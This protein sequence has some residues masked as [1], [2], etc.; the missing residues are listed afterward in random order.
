MIESISVRWQSVFDPSRFL[1]SLSLGIVSGVAG[2]LVAGI[3]A[4]MVMRAVALISGLTPEFTI[5][6]TLFIIVLGGFL[7][8]WVGLIFGFLLP[9]LPG[10]VRLKG[11]LFGLVLSVMVAVSVLVIELEGELALAPKGITVA[12]LVSIPLIYGLVLS[13]VAARLVP[14]TVDI[15]VESMGFARIAGLLTIVGALISGVAYLVLALTHPAV[16]N[17]GFETATILGKIGSI[18]LVFTATAGIAG[19]LRSGAAGDGILVRI[20]LGISLLTVALLGAISIFGETDMIGMHGIVRLFER[21][22]ADEDLVLVLILLLSGISGL[23]VAGIASL[24]TLRW[25]GWR[26][27]TPLF[28]GLYPV[29]CVLILYPLFLPSLIY[30][31]LSTRNLLGQWLGA[32]YPLC[33]LVLGIALRVE[34]GQRLFEEGEPQPADLSVAE[35]G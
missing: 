15:P 32:I 13:L 30:L 4:R 19:L 9:Y 24:L 29:L 8:M 7:G 14:Q 28:A 12:L 11:L 33:W 5:E 18:S 1:G 3:A 6:G 25:A 23:L 2:G 27:Y 35:T 22:R 16:I 10:S 34:T 20:G 26:R 17:L 31:P 21:L